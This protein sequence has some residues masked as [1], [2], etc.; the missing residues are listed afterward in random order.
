MKDNKF[1]FP[2][3]TFSEIIVRYNKIV[4][5]W[6]WSEFKTIILYEVRTCHINRFIMFCGRN[7]RKTDGEKASILS[8]IWCRILD[9]GFE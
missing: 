2:N 1:S 4:L 6:R 5:V 8:F 7:G 3:S 9:L